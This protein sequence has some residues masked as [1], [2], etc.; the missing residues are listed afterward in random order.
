MWE[1]AANKNG[2]RWLIELNRKQRMTELDRLWL[3]IILCMIG[4][5]FN[6]YSSD[7]CG[8]VVNIR[9]KNDKVAVWTADAES[10]TGVMDIGYVKTIYKYL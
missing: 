1:D 10:S 8:A 6:Q 9:G 2:G 5:G 4:E 7:I 3:E